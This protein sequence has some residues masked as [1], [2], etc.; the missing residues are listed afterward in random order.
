MPSNTKKNTKQQKVTNVRLRRRSD[1]NVDHLK[2]VLPK[3]RVNSKLAPRAGNRRV[4]SSVH[5][6]LKTFIDKL[7]KDHCERAKI[8]SRHNGRMTV[9]AKD[10]VLAHR[11]TG[12]RFY[13]A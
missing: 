6:L 9:Q 13:Y 2:S 8:F 11:S 3:A 7:V 1:S 5:P 10:I 12:G 4:K